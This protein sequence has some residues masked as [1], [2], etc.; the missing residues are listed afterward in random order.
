MTVEFGLDSFGDVALDGQGR[1]LSDA[2][3]VRLLVDEAV[4]AEEVGLDFYNI[5]EHYKPG[6]VDTAGH[7]IL[8]AI[9]GKTNR[10]RLGTSVLVLS[11]RDPVRVFHDFSTL[12]AVSSGRAELI[13]GRASQ[14]ESFPLFGFDM[15]D[16]DSLFEE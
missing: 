10:I 14:T 7:V 1:A 12:Q 4:L 2:E 9:A 5:G 16:Y 11:T 3:T 6:Q 13:I 15:A 8:A